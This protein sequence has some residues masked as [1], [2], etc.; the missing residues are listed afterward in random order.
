MEMDY[1]VKE[2]TLSIMAYTSKF[3]ADGIPLLIYDREPF[4]GVIEFHRMQR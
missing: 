1:R 3:S 4:L 2:H